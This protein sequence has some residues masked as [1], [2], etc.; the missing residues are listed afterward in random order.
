VPRLRPGWTLAELLVSLALLGSVMGIAAHFAVH[1]LRFFQAAT[2]VVSL[3]SKLS[4]AGHIVGAIARFVSPADGD[5]LAATDTALEVL[6]PVGTAI[7]CDAA[8]GAI[9]VPASS[10]QRGN[11]FGA[12]FATPDVGDRIAALLDDSLGTTWMTLTVGQ[13]PASAGACPNLGVPAWRIPT[14]EPLTLSFGVPI[15]ILRPLRISF[16]RSSDGKWYLGAKDWNGASAQF[17]GIQPVL[18]PFSPFSKDA[19]KSGLR[20]VYRDRD[21]V[22]LHEPIDTR[23]IG[24]IILLTRGGTDRPILLT[25]TSA[26]LPKTVSDSTSAVVALR[27]VR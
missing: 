25:G 13:I 14:R 18:G 16:Y 3:R 27:N 4:Q 1:Q 23:R 12:Y 6:A 21:G 2:E 26:S 15:R 22:E 8:P 19:E 5:I 10:N 20:F 24:S 17:N 9:V 7:V 11:T